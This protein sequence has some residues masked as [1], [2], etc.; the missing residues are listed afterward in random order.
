MGEYIGNE[1]KEE[2][3]HEFG[4]ALNYESLNWLK[5]LSDSDL[6]DLVTS[7][8]MR[9]LDDPREPLLRPGQEEEVSRPLGKKCVTWDSNRNDYQII[10]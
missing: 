1:E 9:T 10:R 4:Q 6:K 2:L 5:V 3:V 7:M 8:I